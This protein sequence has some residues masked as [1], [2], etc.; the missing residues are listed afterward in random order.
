MVSFNPAFY[1]GPQGALP[2]EEPPQKLKLETIP[3]IEVDFKMVAI[4][5]GD[6]FIAGSDY[7]GASF[8]KSFK[9]FKDF[10]GHIGKKEGPLQE[11]LTFFANEMGHCERVVKEIRDA[12]SVAERKRLAQT[13]LE[14]FEK[15]EMRYFPCGWND[16]DGGHAIIAEMDVKKGT[17][18]LIN[19]GAGLQFHDGYQSTQ[20]S[21]LLEVER[22]KRYNCRYTLENIRKE[23]LL[24]LEFFQ[25]LIELQARP[26]KET[27]LKF[28]AE[29]LYQGINH[30]LQGTKKRDTDQFLKKAQRAGTSAF[31]APA[32][33]L[34]YHLLEKC[35]NPQKAVQ[36]YK[37]LKFQWQSHLVFSYLEKNEE[38]TPEQKHMLK[39]ILENLA[40]AT[41]KVDMGIED[42]HLYYAFQEAL[43]KL[44]REPQGL[45]IAPYKPLAEAS[46]FRDAEVRRQDEKCRYQH[47]KVGVLLSQLEEISEFNEKSVEAILKALKNPDGLTLLAV[48][49]ALLKMP[50]EGTYYENLSPQQREALCQ[51]LKTIAGALFNLDRHFNSSR[52]T[53]NYFTI[54]SVVHKLALEVD[55]DLRK[56]P[57]IEASTLFSHVSHPDF[58]LKTPLE[59]KKLEQVLRYFDKGYTLTNQVTYRDGGYKKPQGGA[60]FSRED[61]SNTRDFFDKKRRELLSQGIFIEGHNEE[62]QIESVRSNDCLSPELN[63]LKDL[64][65][66]YQVPWLTEG[67]E[68]RPLQNPTASEANCDVES[69]LRI[70]SILKKPAKKIFLMINKDPYDQAN[71]A[72]SFLESYYKIL[73]DSPYLSDH[74]MADAA[75]K[76]LFAPGVLSSQILEKEAFGARLMLFFKETLETHIEE[77][78][79]GAIDYLLPFA[80]MAEAFVTKN[81]FSFRNIIL[82][83]GLRIFEQ[84][85]ERAILYQALYSR[86]MYCSETDEQIRKEDFQN[87]LSASALIGSTEE[88]HFF[89]QKDCKRFLEVS[90]TP[91][92]SAPIRETFEEEEQELTLITCN[93]LD[94]LTEGQAIKARKIG[95]NHYGIT[96]AGLHMTVCHGVYTIEQFP[97]VTVNQ[98]QNPCKALSNALC[99]IRAKDSQ[100]QDLVLVPSALSFEKWF[101]YV[102]KEGSLIADDP[103]AML[104]LLVYAID[105]NFLDMASTILTN[106][107]CIRRFTQEERALLEKS[108]TSCIQAPHALKSALGVHALA[109]LKHNQFLYPELIGDT[110]GDKIKIRAIEK[111]LAAYSSNLANTKAHK[112][113]F[114]LLESLFEHLSKGEAMPL[115]HAFLLDVYGKKKI[116]LKQEKLSCPNQKPLEAPFIFLIN[117]SYGHKDSDS[118]PEDIIFS[119]NE[120]F[121]KFFFY[122]QIA[123]LGTP[124]DKKKLKTLLEM[125]SGTICRFHIALAQVLKRPYLYP[126][127][128]NFLNKR[129][130]LQEGR[131]HSLIKTTYFFYKIGSF[132]SRIPSLFVKIPLKARVHSFSKARD[133]EEISAFNLVHL[134]QMYET[135]FVKLVNDCFIAGKET[136][137][138][139]DLTITADS[140]R[141]AAYLAK[142]KQKLDAFYESHKVVSYTLKEKEKQNLEK[143]L[144]QLSTELTETL[145]GKKETLLTSLNAIF[146]LRQGLDQLGEN[147][148]C[149]FEELQKFSAANDLEGL[150]QATYLNPEQA[151]KLLEETAKYLLLTTRKTQLEYAS[152]AFKK[153]NYAEVATFLEEAT[154]HY[155]VTE[156]DV[157]LLWFEYA[158]T[159]HY[160]QKQ[161]E[162]LKKV[163][164]VEEKRILA[165]MPTGFGKTSYIVPSVTKK[166]ASKKLLIVNIHPEALEEINTKEMYKT[167]KGAFNLPVFRAHFDRT[168]NWTAYSLGVLEKEILRCKEKGIAVNGSSQTFRGMWLHY[169]LLL[170]TYAESKEEE[171]KKAL[172]AEIEPLKNILKLLKEA[173][174]ATVDESLD[175]YDPFKLSIY[176]LGRAQDLPE[177]HLDI[178][179]LCVRKLLEKIG[180]HLANNTQYTLKEEIDGILKE[181]AINVLK[182]LKAEAA[183]D[184][185]LL[186]EKASDALK[187]HP[188]YKDICLV[189]GLISL[190]IPES[191]KGKVGETFGLSKL[192]RQEHRYAI[193]YAGKDCPSENRVRPNKLDNPHETL[194]KTL[195]TYLH[196]KLDKEE[197]THLIFSLKLLREQELL[198]KNTEESVSNTAF[199]KVFPESHLLLEK[200]TK[201][202]IEALVEGRAFNE[203]EAIFT[204]MR[205]VIL[206]QIE[207]HPDTLVSSAE[208][209]KN[210]FAETFSFSA[211]PETERSHGRV[212]ETYFLPMVGTQ[213]KATHLLLKDGSTEGA[214]KHVSGETVEEKMAPVFRALQDS[215][216]AVMDAAAWSKGMSNAEVAQKMLETADSGIKGVLFYHENSFML[217]QRESFK[218]VAPE[219]L[220]LNKEERL[221][222]YDQLRTVGS[223][224]KQVL[225]A[226]GLLLVDATTTKEAA[227][228]AAGRLRQWGQGQ[229]VAIFH[230]EGKEA[231][232]QTLFKQWFLNSLEKQMKRDFSAQLQQIDAL[233]QTLCMHKLYDLPIEKA[234]QL[235]RKEYKL[236]LVHT[237]SLDPI[238][239]YGDIE[240]NVF[241]MDLLESKVATTR[242]LL[243]KMKSFSKKEKQ[244]VEKAL[245]SL[246]KEFA[247][248]DFPENLK[249]FSAHLGLSTEVQQEQNIEQNINT[250]LDVDIHAQPPRI[251]RLPHN[252]SEKTDIFKKNFEQSSV[253]MAPI[254]AVLSCFFKI[255]QQV[256]DL[257]SFFLLYFGLVMMYGFLYAGALLAG[258]EVIFCVAFLVIVA[259]ILLSLLFHKEIAR[260]AF[261]RTNRVSTILQEHLSKKEKK[262]SKFFSKNFIASN[263][264]LNQNPISLEHAKQKPFDKEM[265]PLFNCLVFVDTVRGKKKITMMAMDQNDSLF[266]RDKLAKDRDTD[267]SK[268]KKRV[269]QVAVYDPYNDTILVQGKNSFEEKEMKE[270]KEFREL[271]LQAK[272]LAGVKN[273]EKL[274]KEILD[275]K[276]A[277]H[278]IT[279]KQFRA[280]QA[281]CNK[282]IS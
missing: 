261:P 232:M 104:S 115:E 84:E 128:E 25:F 249:G 87:A 61:D 274:E 228:Q 213:G 10:L 192:H 82:K 64:Y 248:L 260:R 32:T 236:L 91:V 102:E 35:A 137:E 242:Q 177:K 40:R 155:E 262:L 86:Y 270:N 21:A 114:E 20:K 246:E 172:H 105:K 129:R 110:S 185:V 66:K 182:E 280:F 31:K 257:K 218:I 176:T 258:I 108:I 269:R 106:F 125:N 74:Q 23:R 206:K 59:Q 164:S 42:A 226:K 183:L 65:F 55:E 180:E 117:A 73:M 230:H 5:C 95:E 199:K 72:L 17:F 271:T 277:K 191:L 158:S 201:L 85:K 170:S 26:I 215:V 7:E 171:V 12:S 43:K 237:K 103:E 167:M 121:N 68:R 119:E 89:L 216:H 130:E 97:G 163:A 156:Q 241:A 214:L 278:A 3:A 173:S 240:D 247:N 116:A 255:A 24:S 153:G 63:A 113:S 133:I 78:K 202:D 203:R 222:L 39:S 54:V 204:F 234:A 15:G 210:Q 198:E 205:H 151:K 76:A 150:M 27:Q 136:L 165:E 189:K 179:E 208:N 186:K 181:V 57:I 275:E 144:E 124:A 193:L 134:D 229:T 51:K 118:F 253:F 2:Q 217:M 225:H 83:E 71:R 11:T 187:N 53:L 8:A 200:L 263:N 22:T 52:T 211:T 231:T 33:A 30:Y 152:L 159:Y 77:K 272:V 135:R 14:A 88:E 223:D 166:K 143:G 44:E 244:I 268:I 92:I 4:A 127:I 138:Q 265:K 252:W 75:L 281:K 188:D 122:Y 58:Y 212:E 194:F 149:T 266:F 267:L 233:L 160:R 111:L 282:V 131:T 147:R 18:S 264:Y 28:N 93:R 195:L 48:N 98:E 120:L 221:T 146:T 100:E 62:T 139:R 184:F 197:L 254:K 279:K 239:M 220:N 70:P 109:L 101:C 79:L 142:E 34:Y 19:R 46:L 145:K 169:Q 13:Y 235:F 41:K 80:F 148:S 273:F 60:L 9:F 50:L 99:H 141:E 161:M 154:R 29:T 190:I 112:I 207:F 16:L 245:A 6:S 36:E 196:K 38:I 178:T 69:F 162:V 209:F 47:Q 94:A 157:D 67:K 49:R 238:S 276:L 140:P 123:K 126:P 256:I 45:K 1:T 90:S 259:T 56:Y 96:L 175:T 251:D 132:F 243:K 224:I 168:S 250:E 219:A 227:Q 107:S 174:F 37:K 81:P